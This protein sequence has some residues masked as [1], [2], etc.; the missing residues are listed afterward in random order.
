MLTKLT[1]CLKRDLWF[2]VPTDEKTT[3]L[4]LVGLSLGLGAHVAVVVGQ[5]GCAQ[6]VSS[7]VPVSWESAGR[8]LGNDKHIAK[9]LQ[10]S[11]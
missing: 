1:T 6:V 8:Q 3:L 5:Q 9:S 2:N 7:G 4:L 10:F 11:P